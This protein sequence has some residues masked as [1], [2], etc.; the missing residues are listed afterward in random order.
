[1]ECRQSLEE[2]EDESAVV[3]LALFVWICYYNIENQLLKIGRETYDTEI[4]KQRKV[5]NNNAD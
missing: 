5:I 4:I 2:L 1:V 3:T